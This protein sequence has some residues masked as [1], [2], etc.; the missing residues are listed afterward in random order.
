MEGGMNEY[1][2]MSVSTGPGCIGNDTECRFDVSETVN[3][4]VGVKM[5]TEPV[6]LEVDLTRCPIERRFRR[7]VRGAPERE[8]DNA[9]VECCGDGADWDEPRG[10][11]LFEE[12]VD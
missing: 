8:L 3:M 2:R 5:R 11:A 9:A 1:A 10:G 7:A 12:V 4:G 6:V